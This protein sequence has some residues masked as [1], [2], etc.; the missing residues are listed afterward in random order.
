MSLEA[1]MRTALT[2]LNSSQ[3]V[4]RTTA[5]NITN[6][7][8]DGYVRQEVQLSSISIG[9]GGVEVGEIRR[10]VDTF[11][12]SEL[13]Q[14]TVS[15]AFYEKQA[16][17]HDR[18]QALL[19]DPGNDT[20]LNNL[21]DQI[22][23]AFNSLS[24]DPTQTARQL[25]AIE[26][27]RF[28]LSELDRIARDIQVLREEA[29]RQIAVDVNLVNA[30]LAEIHDLNNAISSA[31]IKGEGVVSLEERRDQAIDR[32]AGLIDLRV[33]PQST[34]TVFLS[35]TSGTALLDQIPRVLVYDPVGQVNTGT[36]FAEI[37]IHRPDP[38]TGLAGTQLGDLDPTL[39]SGEIKA[40]IDMRDTEFPAIA[41]MFGAL[42]ASIIDEFNRVHNENTTLPAPNTLTGR[43]VGTLGTDPHG[44]TGLATF[45]VLDAN[46]AIS[47]QV[48]RVWVWYGKSK[49]LI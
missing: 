20:A 44:F 5:N 11:L 27:L 24:L 17:L 1:I 42:A 14:A 29:D 35:T 48:T 32:I 25:S 26:D 15:A 34:G 6:V 37:T 45:V 28:A 33:L 8:T 13:V 39:L 22:F 21:I 3:A 9:G 46:S 18:L 31:N 36:R 4:L 49:S 7:N 12:Q 47:E 30:A 2:G 41:E 16:Q 43:D 10:L 19:G 40:L 38:S 23:A